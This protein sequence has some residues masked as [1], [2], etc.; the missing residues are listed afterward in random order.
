[1]Y[2]GWIDTKDGCLVTTHNP[3]HDPLAIKPTLNGK[4]ELLQ[5]HEACGWMRIAET[6]SVDDAMKIASKVSTRHV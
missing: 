5:Q 3:H 6:Y 1:M 2:S 4:Y